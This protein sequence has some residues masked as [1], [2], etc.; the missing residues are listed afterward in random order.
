VHLGSA[1]YGARPSRL[2]SA[3]PTRPF[4]PRPEQG[5]G[6]PQRRR[7]LTGQF[8]VVDGELLGKVLPMA[9]PEPRETRTMGRMDGILTGEGGRRWRKT[10]EGEW[11]RRVW[12]RG[13]VVQ[14]C[15]VHKLVGLTGEW[16]KVVDGSGVRHGELSCPTSMVSGSSSN[17]V[18][19]EEVTTMSF[20]PTWTASR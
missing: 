16:Q 3:Q 18:L 14:A 20:P 12:T 13:V 17:P 5:R 9:M 7:R 11:R 4:G 10:E 6:N 8:R 15:G 2:K 19:E 1:Y